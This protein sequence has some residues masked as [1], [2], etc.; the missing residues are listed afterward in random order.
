MTTETE[1]VKAC[2]GTNPDV[3]TATAM[4]ADTRVGP[5]PIDE[6][7]MT[8]NAVHCAMLVVGKAEDQRLTAAQ[9]WLTQ[10]ESRASVQQGKQRDQRA[11]DNAQHQPRMPAENETAPEMRWRRRRLA[12]RARAQQREQGDCR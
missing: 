8:L 12:P 7:V 11:C 6:I 4:T 2:F 5:A 3:G 10:R 9:E 1:I